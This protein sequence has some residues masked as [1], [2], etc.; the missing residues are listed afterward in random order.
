MAR[1]AGTVLDTV[2]LRPHNS[3]L[4]FRLGLGSRYGV[5]Y[6]FNPYGFGAGLFGYDPWGFGGLGYRRYGG[7]SGY[8]SYSGSGYGS[9]ARTTERPETGSI[10]LRVSPKDASVY[11]D[12]AL[13]GVVDD[14]DG[15]TNHLELDAGSHDL[16][17]RADG[18]EPYRVRIS[19]SVGRT[20][21]ERATMVKVGK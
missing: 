11:I 15:L 4:R 8:R 5:G 20:I 17:L 21:T 7:S 3:T 14:F 2:R 10:R 9:G 19:V 1:P 12:G 18:Y 13:A 16:E 6:G